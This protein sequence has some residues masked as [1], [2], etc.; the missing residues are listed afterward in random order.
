MSTHDARPGDFRLGEWKV[1]PAQCRLSSHGRT[2]QVRARVMDLLVRL[3]ATPGQVISKDTLLDE[4]WGTDAVSES[5]LTRTVTELRQALGDSVEHPRI[6]ETI[7]KRG[8]RLIA[9]VTSTG[10]EYDPTP[11]AVRRITGHRWTFA[12]LAVTL[13]ALV[14][15]GLAISS[16]SSL[17]RARPFAARDWVLV[18][19]FENQTGNPMFDQVLDL[20]LERE[21]VESR[22]VNVV[23]RPRIEDVL[24]LMKK[25]ADTALDEALAREVALRDGGIRALLVGRIQRLGSGYVVRTKVTNPEDGRT[26]ADV[27][28]DVDRAG[29]LMPTIRRQALEV[30]RA[31]GEALESIERSRA[32][33]AKVTTPSLRALQLYSRAAA[34]M[35]GEVWR[36]HPNAQSRYAS[37]EAFLTE[38]TAVD[39]SF[40]SAWLM[41][42]HAIGQQNRPAS[43]SRRIAERALELSAGTSEVERYFIEGFCYSRRARFSEDRRESDAAARAFE[44]VLQLTPDHYWTLLELMPVYRQ[45]GRFEDAERLVIHAATVR[46]R[47]VR[48]AVDTARVY[49][50]RGERQLA[51]TAAAHAE[52]LAREAG[53]NVTALPTDNLEWLRLWDAHE[54]WLDRD[55]ARVLEAARHADRQWAGSTSVPWLFKLAYVYA[56]IGRYDDGLRVAARLPPERFE[57]VRNYFAR[58]TGRTTERQ[59]IPP[60]HS[61]EVLDRHFDK[62]IWTDR[63]AEA[64]WVQAERRRRGMPPHPADFIADVLGQVRVQQG[65]YAEGLALLESLK[66]DPMG[67]RYY[68][69][70]HL[71]LAR[72]GLGDSAGAIR[73]LEHA[74]EKRA[75]AITHDGWQVYSWL[76]CRVLLA[77]LYREIGRSADAERTAQEVR[78][79][80]AVSDPGHPLLVRLGAASAEARAISETPPQAVSGRPLAGYGSKGASTHGESSTLSAPIQ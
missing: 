18:V 56:G 31:L 22:F 39:P 75:E 73:E 79:L 7:P 66:P 60:G 58:Q 34:L 68:V 72:R 17:G 1:D 3:A 20:A 15:G 6:L 36:Y 32:A 53:E 48:F 57:F 80:L 27:S 29:A 24:G 49:L 5:A 77:E 21:L 19:P 9:A 43:E 30:R 76:R 25:P 71:A 55:P 13:A 41:L 67:P 52:A 4:V 63:L 8:Y 70:E 2:V 45:L 65:R 78:T 38:A 59:P 14:V 69:L 35:N 61:F 64:E 44:A 26:L 28:H 10:P 11:N 74:G 40:S 23:P 46:P 12:V 50:R 51:R 62:L 16:G 42:A 54:A 47:S 33:L 37:A